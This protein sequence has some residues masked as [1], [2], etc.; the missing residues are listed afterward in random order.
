MTAPHVWFFKIIDPILDELTL[1]TAAVG[2]AL[3]VALIAHLIGLCRKGD[4]Q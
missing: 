2:V 3:V 4:G 1:L